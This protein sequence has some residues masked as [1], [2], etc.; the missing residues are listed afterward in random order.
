[1]FI[2]DVLKQGINLRSVSFNCLLLYM[3]DKQ[4]S[5]SNTEF[6]SVMIAEAY[7]AFIDAV[8]HDEYIENKTQYQE[9]LRK[10]QKCWNNWMEYR[11]RVS[12]RLPYKLRAIYDGCTN[13]TMRTKLLQLKNQNQA[14]GVTGYGPLNCI[15]PDD[16]SDKALLAYPGFDKVWAIHNKYL[17]WYPRFE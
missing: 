7:S 5:F 12:S 8:G 13:M 4:T 16:C 1:M 6:T 3:Q 17:D 10:E 2:D 11:K 15:I 14:L 9:S